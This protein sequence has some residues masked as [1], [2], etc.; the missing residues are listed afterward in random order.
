MGLSDNFI[1]DLAPNVSI[2][3]FG[4]IGYGVHIFIP[5]LQ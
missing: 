4:K 1:K 3:N 2:S 5:G